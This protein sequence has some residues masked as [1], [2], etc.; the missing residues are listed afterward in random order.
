MGTSSK[1]TSKFQATIPKEVRKTLKLKAGD[2]VLF[3][4]AKDGSVLLKKLRPMDKEYLQALNQTLSE[5]D[6]EYDDEAFANLQ[7]V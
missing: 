4:I 2:S 3:L 7:D 1:L 5:W 6:S